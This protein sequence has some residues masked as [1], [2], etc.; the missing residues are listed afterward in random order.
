MGASME[1]G[2]NQTTTVL[3]LL[4]RWS[5]LRP[6]EC[7]RSQGWMFGSFGKINPSKQVLLQDLYLLQG[8]IQC[9]LTDQEFSILSAFHHDEAEWVIS[10]SNPAN[11]VSSSAID[12]HPA[13]AL[14]RCYVQFLE[15]QKHGQNHHVNC[16]NSR[17]GIVIAPIPTTG[18]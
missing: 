4:E 16:R 17:F 12:D 18:N 8:E 5:V 3:D 14:L 10:I 15:S 11:Q 1:T 9:I 13:I 6:E 7:W 2:I